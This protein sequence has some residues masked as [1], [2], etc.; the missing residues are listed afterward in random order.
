MSKY[1]MKV[2]KGGS[3]VHPG[4]DAMETGIEAAGHITSVARNQRTVNAGGLACFL[5]VIKYEHS[6]HGPVLSL[7]RVGVSYLS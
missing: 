3:T 1:L 7:F 4:W 2:T 5:L 6:T